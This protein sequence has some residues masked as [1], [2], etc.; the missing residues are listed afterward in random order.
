MKKY[1]VTGDITFAFVVEVEA[2]NEDAAAEAAEAMSPDEIPYSKEA[3]SVI[4]D[5]QDV[6]EGEKP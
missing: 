3:G 6:Y 4:V 5:V 2:E 1:I